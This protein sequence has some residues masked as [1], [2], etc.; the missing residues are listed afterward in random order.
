MTSFLESMS[1]LFTFL[2]SQMGNF[3][4]FFTTTTLGMII[5]GLAILTMIVGLVSRLIKR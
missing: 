1:A 4:N 5:I 3:A 2:F